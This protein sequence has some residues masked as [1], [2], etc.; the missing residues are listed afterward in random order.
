M[1]KLDLNVSLHM[2]L[3]ADPVGRV[4]RKT[5]RSKNLEESICAK[6]TPVC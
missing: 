6:L 2:L 4:V 3:C 5:S 1:N